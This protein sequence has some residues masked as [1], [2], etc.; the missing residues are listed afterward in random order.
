MAMPLPPFQF[1]H[2]S[3]PS[4]SPMYADDSHTKSNSI[5]NGAV[6][7]HTQGGS[8]KQKIPPP[9]DR[10]RQRR[11]HCSLMLAICCICMT[12][13][14]GLHNA[15]VRLPLPC[16]AHARSSYARVSPSTPKIIIRSHFQ[17]VPK[18]FIFCNST[19]P[20]L[21]VS[22]RSSATASNQHARH[23]SSTRPP[24]CALRS[25]PVPLF[26]PSRLMPL[27][28]AY[29]FRRPSASATGITPSQRFWTRVFVMF[30]LCK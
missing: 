26:P 5:S 15:F 11:M 7:S 23:A 17:H 30:K 28:Q 4:S 21:F 2:V 19:T 3:P 13:S 1:H 8:K 25:R 27:D 10:C 18:I 6:A 14:S 24:A 9:C 20:L 29:A 16:L 22:N 12:N